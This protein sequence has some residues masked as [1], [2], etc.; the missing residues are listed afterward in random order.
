VTLVITA[1]ALR[2]IERCARWWI[3]HRDAHE[4]FAQELDDA[5]VRIQREPTLG[6]VFRVVRGREQRRVLMPRTAHHVY[7]R[8]DGDDIIVLTVWGARRGRAPAL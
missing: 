6:P 7:Y 2:D 5:L 8:I 1:R 3:S 4:L